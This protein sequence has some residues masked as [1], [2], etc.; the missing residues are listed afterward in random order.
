MHCATPGVPIKVDELRL[1]EFTLSST[2]LANRW[3]TLSSGQSRGKTKEWTQKGRRRLRSRRHRS[4]P[5]STRLIW[6]F[7][8]R[9][10][11]H[12]SV[13]NHS[14]AEEA[15]APPGLYQQEAAQAHTATNRWVKR[16][17]KNFG[18]PENR[19]HSP[20]FRASSKKKNSNK[21]QETRVLYF[22]LMKVFIL[23]FVNSGKDGG[24]NKWV[25]QHPR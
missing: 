14:G 8:R 2:E 10:N 7:L 24:E 21:L 5:V 13:P 11:G 4:L 16:S 20:L 18:R 9:R 15:A 25:L 23:A 6:E 12:Q 17:P 19:L 1:W 22:C 3:L